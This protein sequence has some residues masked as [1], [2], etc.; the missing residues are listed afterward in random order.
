MG[1]KIGNKK[2]ETKKKEFFLPNFDEYGENEFYESLNLLDNEKSK[3]KFIKSIERIIRTSLEYSAY[4]RYLKTTV[5]LTQCSVLNAL[6]EE[7]SKS[8]NIEMHHCPLTLY[9]LVDIILTKHLKLGTNY[10]R[11]SIANDVM[12]SHYQNQIGLVPMT[13]TMHQL[14]HSG[15]QVVNKDDIF[16]DYHAFAEQYSTFLEDEHRSKIE[17]VDSLSRSEIQNTRSRYLQ[18]D[19]ELYLEIDHSDFTTVLLPE[20]TNDGD[21]EDG[22]KTE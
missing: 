17:R 21:V 9:D 15:V 8:L 14:I 5:L 1:K 4:I 7:V 11:V 18:V 3:E 22:A 20:R 6:P 2:A 12:I 13:K 10:T 16:G 19:P